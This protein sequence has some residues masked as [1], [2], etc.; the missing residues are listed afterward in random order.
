L[1]FQL[2][3]VYIARPHIY[4]KMELRVEIKEKGSGDKYFIR[5]FSRRGSDRRRVSE[6]RAKSRCSGHA[7]MSRSR[8][9]RRACGF[10]RASPE[11]NH[12]LL[13]FSGELACGRHVSTQLRSSLTPIARWLPGWCFARPHLKEIIRSGLSAKT[14][15]SGQMPGSRR[16]TSRGLILTTSPEDFIDPFFHDCRA[17]GKI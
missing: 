9:A 7:M 5:R 12:F 14:S 8:Q 2:V 4:K 6:G 3:T 15:R 1:V 11:M 17:T 13:G 16:R 10:S